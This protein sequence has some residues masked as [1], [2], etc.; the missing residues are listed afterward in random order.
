MGVLRRTAVALFC[1]ELW[2]GLRAT[3]DF[4]NIA[5]RESECFP[6]HGL[7]CDFEVP[8]VLIVEYSDIPDWIR[9][10]VG[11][12]RKIWDDVARDLEDASPGVIDHLLAAAR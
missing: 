4:F 6:N 10:D 3:G 7:S 1:T 12:Q 2:P 9:D 8:R 11:M 5:K